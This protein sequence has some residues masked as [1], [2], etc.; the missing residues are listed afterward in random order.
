MWRSSIA[1]VAAASVLSMPQ[2]ASAA[3]VA[4]PQFVRTIPT[5]ETGWF[6]SPAL[7]DLDGDRKLEIVA[8]SYS[9]SVFDARGRRLGKGYCGV[10][11]GELR[12]RLDFRIFEDGSYAFA[13]SIV[14][15]LKCCAGRSTTSRSESC[16]R[17]AA[18][19]SARLAAGNNIVK[20]YT[21]LMQERWQPD[22]R[23]PLLEAPVRW[24]RPV[25]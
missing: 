16:S 2:P 7:V 21:I 10:V 19:V 18:T 4:K 20:L 8:P 22:R 13:S 3:R 23:V 17:T 15:D 12:W 14:W 1:V 9:T 25:A 5:G 24:V 11:S 6:A